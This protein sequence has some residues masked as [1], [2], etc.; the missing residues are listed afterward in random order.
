MDGVIHEY[1][2]IPSGPVLMRDD[3]EFLPMC[4]ALVTSIC[5]LVGFSFRE[6]L[7]EASFHWFGL[8]DA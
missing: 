3:F 6:W 7:F 1:I 4:V 2:A 8:G 5:Y